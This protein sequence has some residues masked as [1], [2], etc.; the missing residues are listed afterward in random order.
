MLAVMAAALIFPSQWERPFEPLESFFKRLARRPVIS[1]LVVAAAAVLLRL[2]LQPLLGTPLPGIHDEFSNLLAADTF[3]HARVTN[4]PHPFW[5]FFESFH[6]L[7]QPTYASMYPP[8]QGLFLAAGRLLF[9]QPWAGVLLSMALLCAALLWM[10]RGWLPSEWALLGAS[11]AIIRLALFSYWVNSYWGGAPAAIGGALVAGSLPRIFRRRRTGDAILFGLGLI[12][13]AASRPFEGLFFSI[14]FGIAFL[15]WLFHGDGR[16]A[17]LIWSVIPLGA[18]LFAGAAALAYYDWRITGNPFETPQMLNMRQYSAYG[19]MLWSKKPPV[20]VYN[21][22]TMRLFYVNFTHSFADA[23]LSVLDILESLARKGKVIVYFFLG[24]LLAVPLI[25]RPWVFWNRRF[26]LLLLGILS[27]VLGLSCLSWRIQPHYFG[28]AT[29]ALYALVLLAMSSLWK[30]K[31]RDR[32]SGRMMV[33]GIVAVAVAM[34]VVRIFS[35]P[36]GLRDPYALGWSESMSGD[37]DRAALVSNLSRGP[38]RFLV[39]VR[40]G[41]NHDLNREWV[42]NEADLSRAKIVWARDRGPETDALIQ[43]FHDRRAVVVEPD[44]NPR[45]AF[46][47][48]SASGSAAVLP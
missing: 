24:P 28:P 5:K 47:Y 18:V 23:P 25:L 17:K 16:R 7:Q 43:Y 14:P 22:E 20:P 12:V 33:R 36:L 38:E 45:V 44:R 41:P 42:Y 10:L 21:N 48:R 27:L 13:L 32:P 35:A 2:A 39:I 9:G 26:R 1:L 4:P 29:C 8:A 37:S 15:L 46:P 6:I 3:L 19:L 30:W 31:W 11:L 40:Y 34:V